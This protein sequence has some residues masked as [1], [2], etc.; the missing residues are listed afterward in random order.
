MTLNVLERTLPM[1]IT[2]RDLAVT[3]GRGP[4]FGPLDLDVP[5]GWVVAIVGPQGSG[6]TSLLLTLSGRMRPSSGSLAV[7]DTDARKNPRRVQRHCAVAGFS[8]IDTLDEGLRVSEVIRERA[9]IVVPL[10]RRPLHAT[11]PAFETLVTDVFGDDPLELTAPIASL[12]AL[13]HARLRV[14]LALIG[15]PELVAVDDVDTVRDPAEQRKL[16]QALQRVCARGLTVVAA[17]T[18]AAAIPGDIRVVRLAPETTPPEPTPTAPVRA[19][20]TLEA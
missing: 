19:L 5:H 2:A 20:I 7:L 11:D 8:A 18:S 15:D 14:L 10:W 3:G 4:V 6:R 9:D 17:A 12:S 13:D 1:A 16:W